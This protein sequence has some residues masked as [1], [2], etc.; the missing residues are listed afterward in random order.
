MVKQA[1]D[2]LA[3]LFVEYSHW[4]RGQWCR[5]YIASDNPK[6]IYIWL[7]NA[8]HN[9]FAADWS[10]EFVCAYIKAVFIL[11]K[12]W[13]EV[14]RC[15]AKHKCKKIIHSFI[16]SFIHQTLNKSLLMSGTVILFVLE[17]LINK[18]R[19]G[20]SN[21]TVVSMQNTVCSCIIIY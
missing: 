6:V 19:V 3:Y 5:K 9:N 12:Y 11:R 10:S 21:F 14:V 13:Q 4:W 16:H 8:L 17:G 7:R 2:F 1:L 18:Y 20:K 15:I